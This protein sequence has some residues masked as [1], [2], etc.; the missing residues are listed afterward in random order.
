MHCYS[1]V[2]FVDNTHSTPVQ[3]DIWQIAFNDPGT[4][5]CRY[6]TVQVPSRVSGYRFAVHTWLPERDPAAIIQI[7]PGFGEAMSHYRAA[8][9]YFTGL[10]YMVCV[11]G[12]VVEKTSIPD[13]IFC[14]NFSREDGWENAIADVMKLHSEL[15]ASRPGLRHVLC[16]SSIGSFVAQACAARF[17]AEFDVNIWLIPPAESLI[18]PIMSLVPR[19]LLVFRGGSAHS[20]LL[21]GY[22]GLRLSGTEPRTQTPAACRTAQTVSD[23]PDINSGCNNT[24]TCMD[25]RGMF[26]GLSEISSRKWAERVPNVPIYLSIA[27]HSPNSGQINAVLKLHKRLIRAGKRDIAIQVTAGERSAARPEAAVEPWRGIAAFLKSCLA[28]VPDILFQSLPDGD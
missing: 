2:V 17:P 15:R 19:A 22:F 8:A 11:G 12:L 21:D 10:G 24:P 25:Y 16:G 23:A 28:S 26:K 6:E 14:G 9:D 1:G 20:R 27:A 18:R 7:I 13:E 3:P 5:M 4:T